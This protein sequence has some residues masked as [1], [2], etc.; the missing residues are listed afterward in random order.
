MHRRTFLATAAA[1]ALAPATRLAAG[2]RPVAVGLT[3]P[4]SGAEAPLG[5]AL[6]DALLTGFEEAGPLAVATEDTASD[7]T[8]FLR[9][10]TRL[11]AGK[12]VASVFGL[13]PP[14]AR[15]G[16][17]ALLERCQGL[18][19][20]PAPTEGGECS[21][22]VIHGGPTPHQSLKFLVPWMAEQV[23]RRFLLVGTDQPWPRELLHVCRHMAGEIG[24]TLVAPPELAP[25]G[26]D[27]FTTTL[28]RARSRDADVIVSTLLDRSAVAFLRQY[29]QAGIDPLTLPVASPTLTEA[30]AA[31]AGPAAAGV[32]VS[33]PYF[34]DE[35][36]VANGLFL[37]RLRLRHRPGGQ[38]RVHAQI[39]AAWVQARLFGLALGNLA[40]GDVSP[41]NLREA[42]RDGEVDTPDGRVRVEGETLHTLLWPKIAVVEPWGRFRILA[43]PTRPVRPLPFW[44]QPGKACTNAGLIETSQ[45]E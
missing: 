28:A 5:R 21:K 32:I 8:R 16:M 11:V 42:A 14:E 45:A 38:G 23:G 31:T 39:E 44:G 36:S 22:F 43:R 37:K 13:C 18:F 20:D 25:P 33:A 17:R 7:P 40:G 34:S 15:P 24:A 26:H 6:R 3:L 27:D 35:V 10:L 9:A 30:T 41:V 29:R 19:W 2:Q 1:A 4:L 12:R